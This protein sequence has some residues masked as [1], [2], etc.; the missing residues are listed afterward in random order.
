MSCMA[1]RG[2]HL[3]IR[4]ILVADKSDSKKLECE[5]VTW[6]KGTAAKVHGDSG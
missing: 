6:N 5:P 2:S 3:Y 1:L 4:T